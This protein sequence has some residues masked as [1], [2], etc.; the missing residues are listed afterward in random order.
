MTVSETLSLFGEIRKLYPKDKA[1]AS[2]SYEQIQ[3][4]ASTLCEMPYDKAIEELKRHAASNKFA[5]TIADFTHKNKYNR[6]VD[7]YKQSCLS[8]EDFE[9]LVVLDSDGWHNGG[10]YHNGGIAKEE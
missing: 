4:W 2:P 10:Q 5:P 8:D 6:V 9:K 7:G 1:F 3:S